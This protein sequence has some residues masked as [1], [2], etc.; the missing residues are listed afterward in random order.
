[1]IY[2]GDIMSNFSGAL[3]S[4]DE[5]MVNDILLSEIHKLL[6]SEPSVIVKTLNE[7]G[8]KTSDSIDKKSLIHKTVDA[9]YDNEKFRTSITNLIVSRNQKFSNIGGDPVSAIASATE[10]ITTAFTNLAAK[11]QDRLSA[12][13]ASKQRLTESLLTPSANKSSKTNMLPI[14]IIGGVLL[15]GGIVAFVALKED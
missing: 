2:G 6:H 3:F 15:I 10:G 14:I 7:S 1:M 5:D 11:K 12:K 13:E 8:L 4:K 9:L